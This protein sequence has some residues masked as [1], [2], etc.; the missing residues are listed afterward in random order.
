MY[1]KCWTCHRSTE[2]IHGHLNNVDIR[3]D[4]IPFHHC[5]ESNVPLVAQTN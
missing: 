1:N 3:L 4:W 2:Q 5:S